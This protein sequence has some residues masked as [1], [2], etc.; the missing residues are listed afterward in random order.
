M[1][2]MERRVDWSTTP[3]KNVDSAEGR[4]CSGPACVQRKGSGLHRWL[5]GGRLKARDRFWAARRRR[6]LSRL[7]T[8]RTPDPSHS[9]DGRSRRRAPWSAPLAQLKA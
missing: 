2:L 9:P 1:A 7:H 4:L 5:G 6:R 3:C 8:R